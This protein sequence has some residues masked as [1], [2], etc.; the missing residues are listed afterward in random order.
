MHRQH[1]GFLFRLVANSFYTGWG[2]NLQGGY[3]F[4]SNYEV[5]FRVASV[6]PNVDFYDKREDLT[7][8]LSKYIIGHKLKIQ[9]DLTYS[10]RVEVDPL[11]PNINSEF[12]LGRLQ[13]EVHF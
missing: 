3:V 7:L 10:S 11:G 2:F 6:R 4:K 9:A 13:M 5:S 1:Y 8:G 12:I